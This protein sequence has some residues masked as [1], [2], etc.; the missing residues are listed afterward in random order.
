MQ[1]A[2]LRWCAFRG[3][4]LAVHRACAESNASAL[5]GFKARLPSILHRSRR[6]FS[7]ASC[8]FCKGLGPLL[9]YGV[10][11]ELCSFRVWA[12]RRIVRVHPSA[13]FDFKVS[14]SSTMLF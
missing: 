7:A 10:G 1:G 4:S 14:R 11:G 13:L 9:F 12:L 2:I 3:L 8:A 5:A 6:A